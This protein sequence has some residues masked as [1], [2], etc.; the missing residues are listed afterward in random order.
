VLE[1][2][3]R[4]AL[5]VVK[6]ISDRLRNERPP[7]SLHELANPLRPPLTRGELGSKITAAHLGRPDVCQKYSHRILLQHSAPRPPDRWDDDPFLKDLGGVRRHTPG[8]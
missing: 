7:A 2:R 4:A 8:P 1:R 3:P 6:E 5:G